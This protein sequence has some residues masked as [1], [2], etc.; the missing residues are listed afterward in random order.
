MSSFGVRAFQTRMLF[1]FCVITT[2]PSSETTAASNAF[3]SISTVWLLR[4]SRSYVTIRVPFGVSATSVTNRRRD[5]T[6]DEAP[7]RDLLGSVAHWAHFLG[8][9]AGIHGSEES[10]VDAVHACNGR[11]H[12]RRFPEDDDA[13]SCLVELDALDELVW[14][15][16]IRER[17]Q[18]SK[19]RNFP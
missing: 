17:S 1:P 11:G 8:A 6:F 16:L 18:S 15:G 19:S 12:D 13:L 3:S 9:V 2:R 14:H 10:T 4:E 7:P 5:S